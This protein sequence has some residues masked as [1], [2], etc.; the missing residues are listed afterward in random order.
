MSYRYFNS[1]NDNDTIAIDEDGKLFVFSAYNEEWI[2]WKP[3]SRLQV[4]LDLGNKALP[5]GKRVLFGRLCSFVKYTWETIKDEGAGWALGALIL[6]AFGGFATLI[7]CGVCSWLSTPNPSNPP[8]PTT[9]TVQYT[10]GTAL[11]YPIQNVKPTV[12]NVMEKR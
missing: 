1:S 4:L 3:A 9:V 8:I 10:D 11:Q 7:I 2:Q 12:V 5:D 6:I